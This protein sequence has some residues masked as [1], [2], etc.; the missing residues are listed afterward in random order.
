MMFFSEL[1]GHEEIGKEDNHRSNPWK[2]ED[3]AFK[4]EQIA[5]IWRRDT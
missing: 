5:L 3:V 2:N 4:D 1:L